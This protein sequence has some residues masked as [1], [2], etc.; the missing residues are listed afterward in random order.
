[1]PKFMT[2]EQV[3]KLIPDD[4]L[5]DAER[6]FSDGVDVL[7]ILSVRINVT[8][9][10]INANLLL[11]TWHF[12]G[13]SRLLVPRIV[14]VCLLLNC[15]SALFRLLVPC[16]SFY[17][18]S[19]KTRHDPSAIWAH[20]QPILRLIAKKYPSVHTIHFLSDGPTTQYRNRTNMF[21]FSQLP[22]FGPF[23]S[24]TWNFSESGDVKGAADGV[25]GSLK[26][27]A[28][29]TDCSG[30]RYSKSVGIV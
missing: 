28:D 19:D 16:T 9:V 2:K 6:Q 13:I 14:D 10:F 15:T 26:R 12:L 18:L 22:T 11:K 4:D 3:Q 24:G 30:R 25:G 27:M 21:L 1:M 8:V 5:T 23:T 17:T 7:G 20:Q 29:K